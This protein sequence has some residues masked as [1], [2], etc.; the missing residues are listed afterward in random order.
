MKKKSTFKDWLHFSLRKG[1][2]Y[3]REIEDEKRWLLALITQTPTPKPHFFI[4][5]GCATKIPA[6]RSFPPNCP[7][8]SGS[9]DRM[10]ESSM[11]IGESTRSLKLPQSP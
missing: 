5:H 6:L 3:D 4:L 10:N 1:T 2:R 9:Y 8:I 11:F 7:V